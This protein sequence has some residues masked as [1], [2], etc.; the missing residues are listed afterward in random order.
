MITIESIDKLREE[1]G[2]ILEDSFEAGSK[3]QVG[4]REL[5][6]LVK[7]AKLEAYRECIAH[8]NGLN[9]QLKP[10]DP[11]FVQAASNITCST[12]AKL[13]ANEMLYCKGVI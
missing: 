12:I 1:A 11:D 7:L 8:A 6:N 5:V 9:K 2:I 10:G 13:I 3:W 4:D